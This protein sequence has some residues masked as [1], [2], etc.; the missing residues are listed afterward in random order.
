VVV[1]LAVK[2]PSCGA[3]PG[4]PC[5]TK[6]G[7]PY[8]CRSRIRA[9]NPRTY[10]SLCEKCNEL[11]KTADDA[12]DQKRAHVFGQVG[13][14]KSGSP[15]ALGQMV[16]ENQADAKKAGD[17]LKFHKLWEHHDVGTRVELIGGRTSAEMLAPQ[18]KTDLSKQGTVIE[19]GH[20]NGKQTVTVKFDDG[21]LSA[22]NAYADEFRKLN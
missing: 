8:Y 20:L 7:V 4:Q 12:G 1:T 6:A 13:T 14:P 5:I 15:N 17:A 16:R 18:P 22:P 2:C 3:E 10:D 9:A 19:V 11:Q 21:S